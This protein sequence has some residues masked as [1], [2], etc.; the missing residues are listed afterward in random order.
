[1]QSMLLATIAVAATTMLAVPTQAAPSLRSFISNSMTVQVR[2]ANEAPRQEDRQRDRR[3]DRR[4]SMVA[5]GGFDASG[6]VL[7][8][9]A[10]EG[11][12]GH[13]PH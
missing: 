10:R 3:Q 8:R 6:I 12:P 7:V 9:E 2:E 13:D 1:M 11:R 4:Q 5:P